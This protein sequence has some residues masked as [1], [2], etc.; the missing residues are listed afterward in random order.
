M[1]IIGTPGSGAE[2]DAAKARELIRILRN[3]Q[4]ADEGV[5]SGSEVEQQPRAISD[6]LW[7][8]ALDLVQKH[9]DLII[10]LAGNLSTE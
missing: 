6:E 7:E 8:S 2:Q 4:H 1:T 5:E 9:A 10:G 3:I